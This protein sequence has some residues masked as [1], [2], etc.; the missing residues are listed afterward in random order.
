MV[1]GRGW[2]RSLRTLVAAAV[3]LAVT[4]C[5]RSAGPQAR[6]RVAA[7]AHASSPVAAGGTT[8]RPEPLAGTTAVSAGSA[9]TPAPRRTAGPASPGASA[10]PAVV[11]ATRGAVLQP[12]AFATPASFS[13][14]QFINA[15][16]GWLGA[17]GQ[18]GATTD[19]G[20][21][22]TWHP[23]PGITP[24]SL[25]F[26]NP[27]DGWLAGLDAACF[28]GLQRA[29]ACQE[30]LLRTT[31]GGAVW[32]RQE[33]LACAGCG[34][35]RIQFTDAAHGWALAGCAAGGTIGLPCRELLR[36]TDGGGTW[37]PAPLP[38]GFRPTDFAFVSATVGWAVGVRCGPGAAGPGVCPTAALATTDGGRTW[39]SERLPGSL[40]GGAD[41]TF[42]NAS[43][44]WLVPS[45]A[46]RCSMGGCWVP[47]DAT[48]DGGRTWSQVASTYVRSGFQGQPQ[49]V[50][51]AVGFV[52][53][54]AG[55]STGKGG[56]ARTT[57]GGRTWVSVGARRD[58]SIQAVSAVN[59]TD[60]WAIGGGFL[61]RS[62]D[63]GRTFTPQLPAPRP[64]TGVDFV[65]PTVGFGVGT[66]SDPGAVLSTTDGGRTWTRLA[67]MPTTRAQ[68]GAVQFVNTRDGWAAGTAAGAG[69]QRGGGPVLLATTDGG[70]R[71]TQR[72]APQ[73]TVMAMRFD[74]SGRGR[75]VT[76]AFP[77]GSTP[78]RLWRT[79]DGGR[80]WTRAGTVPTGS[81]LM[82]FGFVR[83]GAAWALDFTGG[84]HPGFVLRGTAAA[85]GPWSPLASFP[86]GGGL[87]AAYPT[88]PASGWVVRSVH[89][90]G[91]HVRHTE[92]LHTVDGGSTWTRRLP[93]P[94]L[95]VV[96]MGFVNAAD[97]WLLTPTALWSTR[98]G[99][100][101]WT[102]VA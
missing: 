55:A 69:S 34:T 66:A 35:P 2:H 77:G 1:S 59:A 50:D 41:L 86:F 70:H 83:A 82:S 43:D 88:G 22:W 25:S 64:T 98:D 95:D 58:W 24:G 63:G 74:A 101:A 7:A 10:P 4:A 31:D 57:D 46:A 26:V 15:R 36:T 11:T 27:R 54:S 45:P 87:I 94:F 9:P 33:A 38:A 90:A 12:L 80:T 47:L 44:G 75:L 73:G 61:V 91:S 60:V 51:A 97:G 6:A 81:E 20:G 96:D 48:T 89:A 30:V 102:Q 78:A 17:A 5:G 29:G 93:A 37:P 85:G 23:V 72:P 100:G 39:Q 8:G 28:A 79:T 71:W 67:T 68:L 21:A 3:L 42:A 16:D 99:G 49:F 84:A 40:I 13:A 92:L 18:V 52:P 53:V 62:T 32:T 65:S 14:L 19:G 76:S 56:I